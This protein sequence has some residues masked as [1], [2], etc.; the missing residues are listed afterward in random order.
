MSEHDL[1]SQLREAGGRLRALAPDETATLR[2]YER[3]A[4]PSDPHRSRWAAAI[5]AGLVAA[6]IIGLVAVGVADRNERPATPADNEFPGA[7]DSAV[8]D[9]TTA[10]TDPAS[11]VS[12]SP[13]PST[14]VLQP[15]ATPCDA[16]ADA[17]GA[18]GFIVEVV[19]C[20]QWSQG[21]QAIVRR[22][23]SGVNSSSATYSIEGDLALNGDVELVGPIAID[24]L[25]SLQAFRGV[26]TQPFGAIEC[27]AL[28]SDPPDAGWREVCGLTDGVIPPTI[29]GIGSDLVQIESDG[30][31]IRGAVLTEMWPTSGCTLAD[32]KSIYQ[33]ATSPNF[34]NE[35]DPTIAFTRFGCD[36]DVAGGTQAPVY[37]QPG[38]V[39]GSIFNFERVNGTWIVT[40]RGTG[41]DPL[42]TADIPPLAGTD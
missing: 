31:T 29:T 25:D 19:A 14:S 9:I 6:T 3:R 7:D 12:S 33:A 1:D 42:P 35:P 41:N 24:G 18:S 26:V 2:A 11:T 23:A 10:P 30:E 22:Y 4:T 16:L 21:E 28:V 37:M 17:D 39:D 40:D 15:V 5:A 34:G 8:T 27:L 38:T 36:G 32:A 13:A 20:R